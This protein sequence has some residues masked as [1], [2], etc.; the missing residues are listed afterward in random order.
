M[1][2]SRSHDPGSNPGRSTK[3]KVRCSEL[4]DRAISDRLKADIQP[5]SQQALEIIPECFRVDDRLGP[6]DAVILAQALCDMNSVYL[7]TF[8][9]V[10]TNSL[11][12]LEL[13]KELRSNGKRRRKL[14]I[15]HSF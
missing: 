14:R 12:L 7:F 6:T 1:W 9:G 4:G 3:L 15:R 13:E 11:S 2:D 10:L 5:P 8:D